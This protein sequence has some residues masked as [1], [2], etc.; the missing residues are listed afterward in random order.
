MTDF[1]S[2]TLDSAMAVAS[3]RVIAKLFATAHDEVEIVRRLFARLTPSQKLGRSRLPEP[4]FVPDSSVGA[5]RL[6]L[7]TAE[8]RVLVH[9]ALSRT[10]DA[11]ALLDATAVEVSSILTGAVAEHLRFE[12]GRYSFID[13]QTRDII[14][15]EA[16]QS[17]R[18]E[19]HQNLSRAP[20]NHSMPFHSAGHDVCADGAYPRSDEILVRFAEKLAVVGNSVAAYEA[21]SAA[22]RHAPE[23]RRDRPLILAAQ[24]ALWAGHVDD[25]VTRLADV[26]RASRS[27]ADVQALKAALESLTSGAVLGVDV[28]QSALEAVG[29][30][31]D[32]TMSATD[33]RLLSDVGDVISLSLQGDL[34]GSDSGAA[35]L[36]IATTSTPPE[37][38]WSID[39]PAPSPFAEVYLVV[40]T[41]AFEMRAHELESAW[42]TLVGASQRLPVELPAKGI[43]A[44]LMR[45]VGAQIDRTSWIVDAITA[46]APVPPLSY[47]PE[48]P[49]TSEMSRAASHGARSVD[50]VPFAS[51]PETILTSREREV[52]ALVVRQ[53]LNNREIA[54]R[55]GISA[56]TVEVHLSN[57]YKK[58]DVSSRSR[59]TA[60]L[61]H[62]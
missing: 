16:S 39:R 34:H 9:A 51:A 3:P 45:L 2:L 28:R 30:A 29:A 35:R 58:L 25:A 48:I 43:A 21:A 1:A 61:L 22:A 53:G 54:E 15:A 26:S 44:S 42:R 7:T 31:L 11:H 59:L 14:L 41:G 10:D 4:L 8:R 55:L 20:R 56:R 49:A 13:P 5:P 12:R 33:R 60:S 38:P 32:A 18:K 23:D 40:L 52:V 57:V 62:A 19:A 37:W 17:S 47:D 6:E 50:P 27:H 24:A 46:L 36:R